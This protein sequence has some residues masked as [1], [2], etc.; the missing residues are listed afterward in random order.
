MA[1]TLAPG[2]DRRRDALARAEAVLRDIYRKPSRGRHAALVTDLA[3]AELAKV[4]ANAFL[5]TK[6]SFINAIAELCEAAG[7]DVTVLADVLGRDPGSASRAAARPGFR[8]RCLPRTSVGFRHRAPNWAPGRRCRFLGDWTR[9]TSVPVPRGR[10]RPNWPEAHWQGQTVAVLGAPSSRAPTTSATPRHLRWPPPS[11]LGA[12]VTL[13]DPAAA[14]KAAAAC[15]QLV[16]AGRRKP[17]PRMR[18][19]CWC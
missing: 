6:I 1:D 19:C 10:G 4:A 12:G 8:R 2:P 7:A 18:T 11:G 9:S 5:A 3:T 17:R 16:P 14:T 15:P 13:Y